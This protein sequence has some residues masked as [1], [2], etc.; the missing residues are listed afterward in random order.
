M[1]GD[2]IANIIQTN[3]NNNIAIAGGGAICADSF[4]NIYIDSSLF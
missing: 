3:F 4:M 2:S 1:Q